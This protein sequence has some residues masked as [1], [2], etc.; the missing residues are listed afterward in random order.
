MSSNVQHAFGA[1]LAQL[2]WRELAPGLREKACQSGSQ[3]FRLVEFAISFQEPD[4]CEKGHVGYV[5][6]GGIVVDINGAN[7]SYR[8]GDVL[9]IPSGVRH[10]HVTTIE[11]ATLFLVENIEPA[12]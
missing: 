2:P 9:N 7:V 3:R 1:S 6:S 5:L 8:A 12:D 4:W 10:K 11:T